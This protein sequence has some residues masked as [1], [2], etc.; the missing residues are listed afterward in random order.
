MITSMT[1]TNT[2]PATT[3]SNTA[4]L[5][6]T[7]L[8]PEDVGKTTLIKSFLIEEFY[9]SSYASVV[10]DGYARLKTI[11]DKEYR[12]ILVDT[13]GAMDCESIRRS[14]YAN[15]DCLILCYAINSPTS[16]KSI[17]S[18]WLPEIRTHCKEVPVILVGTKLDLRSNMKCITTK[19]GARLRK[20]TKMLSFFE[21][22]SKDINSL[23]T[24]II[25][26]VRAA[27]CHPMVD[28]KS[29]KT[30]QQTNLHKLNEK[31]AILSK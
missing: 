25:E 18:Y 30:Q 13:P 28:N 9:D 4:N 24:L 7:L 11:D 21:C 12:L 6:I 10:P 3:T 31:L 1:A 17:S 16:F 2:S 20:K 19:Q 14:A 27:V 15:S 29:S 26:A 22:S 8:G 23:Q 5:K